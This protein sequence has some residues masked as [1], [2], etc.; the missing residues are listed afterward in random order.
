MI[1]SLLANRWLLGGLVAV[2]VG[3]GGAWM[4]YSTGY[5][6]GATRV[7]TA[8]DAERLEALRARAEFE[9]AARKREQELAARA[10]QQRKELHREIT[11]LEQRHAA[12]VDSLRYRTDR[13]ADGGS[14]PGAATAGAELANGCTGAQLYRPDGEFL[15]GEAARADRLRLALASCQRAYESLIRRDGS[16]DTEA[17]DH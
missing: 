8:W 3:A 1:W 9:T 4:A 6:A 15:A 5:E 13:P 11:R 12:I 10:A 16:Q 17:T 7:Q 14:V 2:V